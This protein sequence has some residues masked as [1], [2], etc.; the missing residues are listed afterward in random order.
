MRSTEKRLPPKAAELFQRIHLAHRN[1]G[2]NPLIS[3][4]LTWFEFLRAAHASSNLRLT[5]GELYVLLT[6]EYGWR[7]DLAQSLAAEYD[8]AMEFMDFLAPHG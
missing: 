4:R 2:S 8:F 7:N 5:G 6:E 3:E 1:R